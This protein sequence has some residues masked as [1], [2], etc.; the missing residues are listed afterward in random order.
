V[1]DIEIHYVGMETK[2]AEGKVTGYLQIPVFVQ[3]EVQT[4]AEG[5]SFQLGSFNPEVVVF[6]TTDTL[7][8]E[9]RKKYPVFDALLGKAKQ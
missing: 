3:S 7:Q 1:S 8:S 4:N 6:F 2:D 9:M 5:V